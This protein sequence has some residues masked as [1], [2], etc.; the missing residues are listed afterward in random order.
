M[1]VNNVK[2]DESNVTFKY[3][4]AAIAKDD[5]SPA[6]VARW[7]YRPYPS[8]QHQRHHH[9]QRLEQNPEQNSEQN[10]EQNPEQNLEHNRFLSWNWS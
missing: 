3:Q 7:T 2:P 10:P 9:R 6:L 4:F 1:A 5:W 8:L